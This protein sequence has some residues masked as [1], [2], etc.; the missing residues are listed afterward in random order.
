MFCKKGGLGNFAKFI[1]NTC[2]RASFIF[3][4]VA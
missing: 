4:K 3:D 1:E 2:A